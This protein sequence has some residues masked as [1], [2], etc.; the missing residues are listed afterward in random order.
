MAEPGI[1]QPC[2]GQ[3]W[4][5]S[6]GVQQRTCRW[7]LHAPHCA[8]EPGRHHA[9]RS[10]STTNTLRPLGRDLVPSGAQVARGLLL[11]RN[12]LHS[13][14]PPR[15]FESH[16]KLARAL[17]RTCATRAHLSAPST[18]F[19][20][21]CARAGS[22]SM[23]KARPTCEVLPVDRRTRLARGRP[24]SH[25]SVGAILGTTD[26]HVEHTCA[27]CMFT[28]RLAG[29]HWASRRHPACTRGS[30]PWP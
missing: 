3:G 25:G 9:L 13:L 16:V 17:R 10:T 18:W 7:Q 2:P 4:R 23:G 5:A 20:T 26:V 29:L 21:L 22:G 24:G 6:D 12:V 30:P 27:D 19:T 1:P 28:T 15:A 14:L 11:S 8:S